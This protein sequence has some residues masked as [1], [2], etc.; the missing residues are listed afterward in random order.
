MFKFKSKEAYWHAFSTYQTF[1]SIAEMNESIRLFVS[2]YELSDSVKA[3]LNTLKLHSKR[4]F[5]VCWLY[6][7]QLAKKAGVSLSSVDRAIKGL[8]ESGILTVKPLIHTKRGG[9]THNLYILNPI[10]VAE[11]IPNEVASPIFEEPLNPSPARDCEVG[12]GAHKNSHTNSNKTLKDI[13]ITVSPDEEILKHVPTEFIK[14]LEPYYAN[15]P[16]V[17][18]DRWNT[19][20]T[21]LK[22]NLGDL[23]FDNWSLIRD[24]WK[25]VVTFYKRGKIKNSTDDGLGAYF[26][27]VLN[28]YLMDYSLRKAFTKPQV[29]GLL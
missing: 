1:A 19:I 3:V 24:A 28:D 10:D 23:Y 20:R 27:G 5:G 8:K 21:A 12:P 29:N 7:E 9:R 18:S 14:I 13:S 22:K 2:T 11:D 17:I 26:Y 25:E 4:Y 15:S 6:K 16:R